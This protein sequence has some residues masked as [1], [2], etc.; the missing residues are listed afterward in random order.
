MLQ[1][2]KYQLGLLALLSGLLMGVSWPTHGFAP[3]LFI[4]WV[5]LLVVRT[6]ILRNPTFF[7]RGAIVLYSFITFLTFNLFTTWWIYYSTM[8][9]ALLAFFLN[10]L[11]MALVVGLAHI[12]DKKVMRNKSA[13]ISL[14]FFYVGFEYLHMNWELS[15]SWLNMGNVF[16][17]MPTWVQWYEYTGSLGGSMWIISI[18][19]IVFSGLLR[20]IDYKKIR[21]TLL[22][23]TIAFLA[24]L[25]PVLFSYHI[26]A[27]YN[28]DKAPG[29]TLNVLLVQP[30]V[31]PYEEA[32]TSTSSQLVHTI[33]QL[34]RENMDS[35]TDIVIT[36]E[37]SINR[38]MWESSIEN[39]AAIDSVR[40]F[41][42]QHPTI[43]FLMGASTCRLLAS[44]EKPKAYAIALSNYPGKYYYNY[45]TAIFIKNNKPI[46]FYHKAKLVPGV[47]R[48]PFAE[49]LKPVEKYAIDLGGTTGSLG[50]S[51]KPKVFAINSQA[52]VAPIICY[53]SI[54]GELV[55]S[56]IDTVPSFIAIITN[57]AWWYNSPG[58]RQHFS[59]ARLRAVETRRAVV[60]AANTGISG[61]INEEGKVLKKTKFYDKTA[62]KAQVRLHHK[63][64]YYAQHGDYLG[65]LSVFIS[66]LLIL[67]AVSLRMRQ[68]K[69]ITEDETAH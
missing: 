18:N 20:W 44:N 35:N 55:G 49:L 19:L 2:R 59:Y 65:Q 42:R 26:E 17:E 46:E 27:N 66:C 13:F 57:D 63:W 43:S 30:N 29:N 38:T 8:I 6:Y 68:K 60:R 1:L 48:M 53:E 28:I 67:I 15:W 40:T 3:I 9:G 7:S 51:K 45:N 12:V 5:P 50:T 10:S 69:L 52:V 11:F 4:A 25:I 37:S 24:V 56:F 34:T 62:I 64:T 47:E 54:Y 41:I 33:L 21:F 23:L 58:H 32:Y 22:P 31:E 16:S 14:I 61:L 39:Y 36:P